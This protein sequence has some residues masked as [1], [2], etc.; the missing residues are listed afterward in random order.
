MKKP[1]V[2]QHPWTL[3]APWWKWAN[4]SNSMNG[5]MTRPALQKYETSKLVD[6]FIKNPQHSLK[7]MDEDLVHVARALTPVLGSN[8]KS[9]RLAN[10]EYV[11]DALRTRKI[12]STRTSG[13]ILS[14][15]RFT[16]MR[17][18]F[19]ERHA[20]MCAMR[21]SLYG[22]ARRQFRQLE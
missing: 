19:R 14:C 18:D 22:G 9:R 1:S 8:G 21:V 16:A 5:R 13:S 7:W 10:W 11:V 6:E 20:A 12:F 4:P 15:A 17:Q 3:V 2:P